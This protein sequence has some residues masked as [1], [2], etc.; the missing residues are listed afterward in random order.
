MLSKYSNDV[1]IFLLSLLLFK[2]KLQR[3]FI[4][5]QF[6]QGF[7]LLVIDA[8]HHLNDPLCNS[9]LFSKK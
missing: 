6:L 2:E 9:R 4:T 1:L 8:E 5:A 3:R 7:K